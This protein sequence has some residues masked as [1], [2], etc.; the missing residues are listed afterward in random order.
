MIL[1]L[2]HSKEDL[3]TEKVMDYLLKEGVPFLRI[4]GS[5]LHDQKSGLEISPDHL[6]VKGQKIDM[7]Q[8]NS[9]WYRRWYSQHLLPE[10]GDGANGR[11]LQRHI[12]RELS[13]I[14]EY[15]FFRLRDKY[16]LNH[17][18]QSVKNKLVVL[19]QAK[20]HGLKVPA[21]T[22]VNNKEDLRTFYDQYEGKII[23]KCVNNAFYYAD[24]DYSYSLYTN[25]VS[26]QDIESFEDS[27]FP[28][29][30]QE[31]VEKDIE[32]RVFYLDGTFYASALFSQLDASSRIDLKLNP[33][34]KP[35]RI[36]PF[37]LPRDIQNKLEALLKELRL[38]T[39]S[40]DLIKTP[41]GDY[42]F[43]EINPVGQFGAISQLNNFNLNLKIAQ[44]LIKKD[45]EFGQQQKTKE[46][47]YA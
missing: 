43:I 31:Q 41:D 11:E 38:N 30:F 1:I 36:V 34:G 40:I 24:G 6:K 37:N 44:L 17:P 47:S 2:S 5:D 10:I 9:I 35:Q 28:T 18:D 3:S 8:I 19:D 26:A 20:K 33:V 25:K 21:F 29:H 27:F 23:T 39:A 42:Q 46:L 32:L 7:D 14:S 45:R 15:L 22:I 16:W 4:N 12:G 13:D